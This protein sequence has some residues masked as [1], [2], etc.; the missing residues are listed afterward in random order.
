MHAIRAGGERDF[1]VR[2]RAHG[3]D[4]FEQ[5]EYRRFFRQVFHPLANENKAQLSGFTGIAS[6]K[7]TRA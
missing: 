1:G 5:T 2:G 6:L 3:L 7:V 4:R